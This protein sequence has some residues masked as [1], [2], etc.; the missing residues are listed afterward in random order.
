[1]PAA[2][3]RF[4]VLQFRAADFGPRGLSL[5]DVVH[6][7]FDSEHEIVNKQVGQPDS[8]DLAVQLVVALWQVSRNDPPYRLM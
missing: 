6:T 2:L 5:A 3:K 4:P 7:P 1:M 8:P